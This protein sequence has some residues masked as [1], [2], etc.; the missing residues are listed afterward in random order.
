[1]RCSWKESGEGGP[2]LRGRDRTVIEEKTEA[3]A[4]TGPKR[5]GS[6]RLARTT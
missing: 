4:E 6:Q 2:V 5:P 1:M 3:E